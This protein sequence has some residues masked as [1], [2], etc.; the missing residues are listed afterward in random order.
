MKEYLEFLKLL[1]MIDIPTLSMMV[2]MLVLSGLFSM[3][4]E[5]KIGIRSIFYK[6]KIKT[7]VDEIVK[8]HA[9]E[10]YFAGFGPVIQISEQVRVS[11]EENLKQFLMDL[12]LQVYSLHYANR[13]I[14]LDLKSLKYINSS[15]ISAIFSMIKH[16]VA[17]NEI[18]ITV[19]LP[20]EENNIIVELQADILRFAG[21]SNSISV[22]KYIS[23]D[24]DAMRKVM[25]GEIANIS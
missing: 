19:I 10:V 16:V 12:L 13:V 6:N 15:G 23:A 21:I 4:K 3:R 18:R 24:C 9:A 5:I 20:I 1:S 2:V 7:P 22:W 11:D 25:P 14:V 8:R 17:N